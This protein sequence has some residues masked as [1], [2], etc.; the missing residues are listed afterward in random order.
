MPYISYELDSIQSVKPQGRELFENE[1]DYVSVDN[2]EFPDLR[3]F[4]KSTQEIPHQPQT[5]RF[6]MKPQPRLPR[7]VRTPYTPRRR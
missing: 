6:Y 4:F 2:P 5:I 1:V 3:I 7:P